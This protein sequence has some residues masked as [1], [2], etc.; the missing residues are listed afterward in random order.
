[1]CSRSSK[2]KAAAVWPEQYFF[3]EDVP[4]PRKHRK[5]GDEIQR[6]V[7]S[8]SKGAVRG[9][10]REVKDYLDGIP[11]VDAGGAQQYRT[12]DIWLGIPY[13]KAPVGEYRSMPPQ[14]RLLPPLD[15]EAAEYFDAC[16]IGCVCRNVSTHDPSAEKDFEEKVKGGGIYRTLYYFHWHFSMRFRGFSIVLSAICGVEMFAVSLTPSSS[17]VVVFGSFALIAVV[18]KGGANYRSGSE[19]WALEM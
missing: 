16:M 10:R 1:M 14:E 8:T 13:A 3:L 11:C 15:G 4:V 5:D 6:I 18:L 19:G 2:E 17:R 9:F 7:V 12:C